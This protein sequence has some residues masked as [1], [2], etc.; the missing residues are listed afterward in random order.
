MFNGISLKEIVY[1]HPDKYRTLSPSPEQLR[2]ISAHS[3]EQIN[4]TGCTAQQ[5]N[6]KINTFLQLSVSAKYVT[7]CNRK[8]HAKE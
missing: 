4:V 8:M 1:G 7:G 3:E 5:S 6:I 2:N